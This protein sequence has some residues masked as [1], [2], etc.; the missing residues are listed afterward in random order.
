MVLQTVPLQ[1]L[2]M[3]G[4]S[5][6]CLTAK[7]D[8]DKDTVSKV[9]ALWIPSAWACAAQ[10]CPCC[11]RHIDL[12]DAVENQDFF[13]F[14]AFQHVLAQMSNMQRQPDIPTPYYQV[15]RKYKEFE[16][17]RSALTL[18]PGPPHVMNA[19]LGLCFQYLGA[20]SYTNACLQASCHGC[21]YT[22]DAY[23]AWLRQE[24]CAHGRTHC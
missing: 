9:H 5:V 4:S 1:L 20:A 7:D 12:W 19:W 18:M 15:L 14:E 24:T 17:R 23:H 6:Q 3:L 11:H 22:A 21:T 13:S 16:I 2:R 10:G 8:N